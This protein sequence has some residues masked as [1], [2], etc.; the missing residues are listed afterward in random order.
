MSKKSKGRGIADNEARAIGRA[1]RTERYR[2][3]EWKKIGEPA[4]TA[5][6]ELYDYEADP[7]ERKNLAAAQ[8]EIVAQ[9][10]ALLAKHPEAKPQIS[11]ALPAKKAGVP[12]K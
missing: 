6:L 8:P 12:P 9:L 10:R 4:A 1:I 2:L 5:E 11:G 7:L 3:V